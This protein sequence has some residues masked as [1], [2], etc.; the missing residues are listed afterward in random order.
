[1]NEN[2]VKFAAWMFSAEIH[3][4]TPVAPL[5]TAFAVTA[6]EDVVEAAR[7]GEPPLVPLHRDYDSLAGSG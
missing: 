5:P 7:V 3:P 6:T 4:A 1:M 2:L